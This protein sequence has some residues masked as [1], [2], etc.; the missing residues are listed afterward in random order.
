MIIGPTGNNET[1]D[2]FTSDGVVMSSGRPGGNTP[3]GGV[4]FGSWEATGPRSAAM[5][6]V[7][8]VEFQ[9][10]PIN[11]T[12]RGV[13]TVDESGDHFSADVSILVASPDGQF[14]LG[15][16]TNHV[17]ANRIHVEPVEA[18]LIGPE[19][20]GFVLGGTPPASASPTN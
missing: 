5:T 16:L 3:R 14:V 19:L 18:G 7:I 10:Q 15:H 11:L 4:G 17:T 12:F 20:S 8:P 9:G 6:F 13:A 2:A 1:I